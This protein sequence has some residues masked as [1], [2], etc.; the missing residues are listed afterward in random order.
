[1]LQHVPQYTSV[2]FNEDA[3][4]PPTTKIHNGQHNVSQRRRDHIRLGHF[5]LI[6]YH[7]QM[8]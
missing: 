5:D 7:L 4:L 1:M 6:R 3:N 2:Q 8:Y